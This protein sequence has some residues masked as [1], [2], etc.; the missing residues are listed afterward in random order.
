MVTPTTLVNNWTAEAHK[1][2][3]A[4]LGRCLLSITSSSSKSS[5]A[6]DAEVRRFVSSHASVHPLLV[7]SY[8]M[9]RIYA[10]ALN[11]MINL[12]LLICDEG[13]RIKNALG[14][15]TTLA[16][17]NCVAMRRLVLTGTPLQNNLEE[18]YAV[19][20][21]VAPG[22]LGTL[23]EFQQRFVHVI[24]TGRM[25]QAERL[26]IAQVAHCHAVH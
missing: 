10:P 14:T 1:W 23:K 19:V 2:F 11:T 16:L 22:Y 24:S 15:K 12:E 6:L 21:F 18:L 3:P 7:L 5:K 25:P 9:F 4:T 13:H 26:S 8:E 20:H 17:G